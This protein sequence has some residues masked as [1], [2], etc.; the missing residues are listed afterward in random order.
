MFLRPEYRQRVELRLRQFVRN[1]DD[2]MCVGAFL[3]SDGQC[4]VCDHHPVFWH[5]II[6]NLAS[7][8]SE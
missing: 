6:E 4:K 2:V 7:R 8:I 1:G 5:Y 3:L